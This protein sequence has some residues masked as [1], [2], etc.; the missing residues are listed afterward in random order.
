MSLKNLEESIRTL[1][2]VSDAPKLRARIENLEQELNRKNRAHAEKKKEQQ[3]ANA[4]LADSCRTLERL[5]IVFKKNTYS[6]RE[7]NK[8]ARNMMDKDIKKQIKEQA[9]N[10]FEKQ[11]PS[12]IETEMK[13]YPMVCSDYTRRIVENKAV[14][15]CDK[16]LRNPSMWPN[17]FR[18]KVQGEADKQA[19]ERMNQT[20]WNNVQQ[21]ADQ[22]INYRLPTAWV[23]FLKGY[24]TSFMKNTLQDQ[25][26]SLIAPIEHN[27]P[28]CGEAIQI[29]I[30]PDEFSL[31]LR[32]GR[33]SY[34]CPFCKGFFK[35]NIQVTLGE[36]FWYILNGDVILRE[37]RAQYVIKRIAVKVLENRET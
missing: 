27:C 10:L 35:N 5:R 7:M 16:Y 26:R 31:M 19:D 17:W 12:L 24:A 8:I 6:I 21:R 3:E 34:A 32:K 18:E 25:L 29:T 14:Q 11:L 4:R 13:G 1:E 20:F 33:V 9:Q 23:S 28:K 36:L 37:T 2:D 30:T 15:L 22:E